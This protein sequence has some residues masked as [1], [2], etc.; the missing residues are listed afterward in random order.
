MEG[1]AGLNPVFYDRS[2]VRNKVAIGRT[3]GW[4]ESFQGGGANACWVLPFLE[5]LLTH[6][7][8]DCVVGGIAGRPESA[9]TH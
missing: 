6:T 3:C 9:W 4:I 2:F 1:A 5:P 7:S 8:Y